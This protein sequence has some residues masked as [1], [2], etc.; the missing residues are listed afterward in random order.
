MAVNIW[1]SCM[2]GGPSSESCIQAIGDNTSALGWLYSTSRLDTNWA[3]NA[4][5]LQV[6][7]KIASLLMKF[8]CCLAS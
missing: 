7:R 3:A 1:L 4:A 2:G 5:H 8:Y 6:A